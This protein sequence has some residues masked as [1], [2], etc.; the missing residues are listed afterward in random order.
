MTLTATAILCKKISDSWIFLNQK[1]APIWFFTALWDRFFLTEIR[2][3]A[4]LCIKI[5]GT[6]NCVIHWMF[7]HEL[8]GYCETKHFN[9][10][11]MNLPLCEN[12][13]CQNSFEKSNGSHTIFFRPLRQNVLTEQWCPPPLIESFWYQVRFRNTER[14]A[15]EFFRH[16]ET[17]KNW[18]KIVMPFPLLRHPQFYFQTR[19][20]LK[21]RRV[22]EW[23][24]SVLWDKI[25]SEKLWY[26]LLCI[27]F[28]CIRFF[29][30]CRR[31]PLPVFSVLCDTKNFSTELWCRHPPIPALLWTTIFDT[32]SFLKNRCVPL[33]NFSLVWKKVQRWMVKSSSDA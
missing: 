13:W 28:C 22:P 11:V 9:K 6:P 32:R 5:F 24:F 4:H 29:L 33:R 12:F 1:T 31:V 15:Y 18:Q 25:F 23:N 20:F 21:Q 16:C 10:T 17:K 19:K 14:F 8:F 2:V 3:T 7:P 27:K 26:S 30:K